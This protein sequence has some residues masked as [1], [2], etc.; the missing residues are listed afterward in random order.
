MSQSQLPPP[1][2]LRTVVRHVNECIDL[3]R[4]ARVLLPGEWDAFARAVEQGRLVF[5]GDPTG[6]HVKLSESEVL[7]CGADRG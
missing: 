6:F 3:E 1:E 4:L 5:S 2:H 7:D